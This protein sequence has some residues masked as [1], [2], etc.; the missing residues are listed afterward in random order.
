MSVYVR[1]K[2]WDASVYH[3]DKDCFNF[4]QITKPREISIE[5]ATEYYELRECRDCQNVDVD[6][7]NDTKPLR[8][9][10]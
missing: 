9:Q 7:T 6:C 1:R 5:R 10:V 2:L 8:E 3:T 4:Q